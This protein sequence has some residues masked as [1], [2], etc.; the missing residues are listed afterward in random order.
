MKVLMCCV[1]LV[2]MAIF[3]SVLIGRSPPSLPRKRSLT[4]QPTIKTE[5]RFGCLPQ[6]QR[7][8]GSRQIR[9][10]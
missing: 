9:G 8:L 1:A 7:A 10:Q 3:P 5:R 2:A 6:E 4:P